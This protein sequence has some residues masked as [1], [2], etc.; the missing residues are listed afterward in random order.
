MTPRPQL[1]DDVRSEIARIASKAEQHDQRSTAGAVFR[2]L[3]PWRPALL[4]LALVTG[5][6]VPAVAVTGV[7]DS[8]TEPDG[9]VRLSEPRV[10]LDGTTRTYGRWELVASDS[11]RGP[12]LGMR[13]A[14]SPNTGESCGRRSLGTLSVTVV[15]DPGVETALVY[16]SAP[17]AARQIELTA[18]H[19]G[20]RKVPAL[21]DRAG[22]EGR[23]YV[24]EV[25]ASAARSGVTVTASDD[26]ERTVEQTSLPG[27]SQ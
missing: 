14:T 23:F 13:V 18:G 26:G 1:L 22:L 19:S 2:G 4:A 20:A 27:P 11:D 24:A 6:G 15:H 10:V 17:D 25:P 9:L 16:G 3:R 7:F 21:D 8:Y 5:L 12:C